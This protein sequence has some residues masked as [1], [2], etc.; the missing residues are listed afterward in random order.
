MAAAITTSATTIEGQAMEIAAAL[1]N[2][3]RDTAKNPDGLNNVTFS[4][5]TDANSASIS[6]AVPVTTAIGTAGKIEFVADP[7]L[8]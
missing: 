5:D 8:L 2:L 4:I 7:Y 3:E 1:Q 6:I